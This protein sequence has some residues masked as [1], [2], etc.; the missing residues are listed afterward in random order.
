M[1]GF[2]GMDDLLRD[3]SA[4]N[5]RVMP[6]AA[7]PALEETAEQV[8]V[9]AKANTPVL[10]GELRDSIQIFT[11]QSSPT[12]ARIA[13]GS[14]LFW[15]VQVEDGGSRNVARHMV[16]SALAKAPARWA[17]LYADRLTTLLRELN[18]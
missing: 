6:E 7:Y 2:E 10:T 11:R 17:A 9:D 14:A 3:L 5:A 12:H 15:A 18:L 4:F 8:V 16:G 13:L 1:S